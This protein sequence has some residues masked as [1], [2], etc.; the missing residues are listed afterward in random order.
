MEQ[1]VAANLPGDIYAGVSSV[2]DGSAQAG[3]PGEP[4]KPLYYLFGEG[5][6]DNFA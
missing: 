4:P 6:V 3:E 1:R 2:Y 5:S